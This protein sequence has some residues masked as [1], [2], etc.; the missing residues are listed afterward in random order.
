MAKTGV[1][2]DTNLPFGTLHGVQS[3][4]IY[5]QTRRDGVER[6]YAPDGKRILLKG[7]ALEE[8]GGAKPKA[9][10]AAKTAAKPVGKMGEGKPTGRAAKMGHAAT[11]EAEGKLDL[12]QLRAWAKS[13]ENQPFEAVQ[14][15]IKAHLDVEVGDETE[16]AVALVEGGVLLGNEVKVSA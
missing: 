6:H 2:F 11:P 5:S 10:V 7:Q 8:W 4:A 12:N 15:A 1:P 9:T 13:E 14:A 16:A 3:G